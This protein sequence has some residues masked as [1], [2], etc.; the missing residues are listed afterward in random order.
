M[1]RS[2]SLWN[3]KYSKLSKEDI[4]EKSLISSAKHKIRLFERTLD[5]L[6]INRENTRTRA[7]IGVLLGEHRT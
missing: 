4:R 6:L 5:T 2:K 7:E 1:N 3:T